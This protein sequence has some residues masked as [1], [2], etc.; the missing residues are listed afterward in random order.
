MSPVAPPLAIDDRVALEQL[1]CLHENA[2]FGQILT[3]VVACLCVYV[4]RDVTTAAL[5]LGWLATVCAAAI[6]R[7]LLSRHFTKSYSRFGAADLRRWEHLSRFA[8]LFSGSVW[9][10]GG[11]L[12]Y[13]ETSLLNEIFLCLALLALASA[14][15]PLLSYVRGTYMMYAC[16]IELP[17][18]ATF[19]IK[20]GQIYY[21]LAFATCTHLIAQ[22]I[23]SWRF[24]RNLQESLRLRFQNE[25]LVQELS[26]SQKN[27]EAAR[28]VA[29]HASKAKS[30]FLANMSHEIRTP[31]NAISG[32]AFLALD[33]NPSPK[34]RDYLTKIHSAS[35]SLLGIVNDILDFSKIEAGKLALERVC[36]SIDDVITNTSAMIEPSATN[37]GLR[38]FVQVD[39]AVPKSLLGDPLRL[40]QVILN[41]CSNAVKFTHSGGVTLSISVA[42]R[43]EDEVVL[44][45]AVI[46]TGIGL[47]EDQRVRLFE[48]F[49]QADSSTTRRYGG[50]GLGL[51]ISRRLVEMMEGE[52]SVESTPGSGSTFSFTVRF[53]LPSHIGEASPNGVQQSVSNRARTLIDMQVANDTV[54]QKLAGVRLLVAED[55]LI[56]QQVIREMLLRVGVGVRIAN[57][58]LE[59]IRAMEE[60]SFDGILMDIH[61]PE[62]D[63]LTA[64]RNL[65]QRERFSSVPIL[66]LTASALRTDVD[67]CLNAG[68]SDH[69]AKPVNAQELYSKLVHWFG[70][71]EQVSAPVF[72]SAF[73]QPDSRNKTRFST[74]DTEGAL[75]LIGG[76]TALYHTV[77]NAFLET[78][79]DSARRIQRA[80]AD[81]DLATAQR[82]VHSLKSVAATVGATA[83]SAAARAIEQAMREKTSLTSAQFDELNRLHEAA[84]IAIRAE[85]TATA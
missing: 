67:Q 17:V 25:T 10:V 63:G 60:T 27:A 11:V 15:L 6:A 53:A 81:R 41:L 48:A 69:I 42:A 5:M 55:N 35:G 43:S 58:G 57:N 70:R 65:R 39:T 49:T 12:L 7:V 33:E 76:D 23:G 68:M 52:V 75:R 77:L 26:I 80:Y 66:A 9:G 64:T 1:R 8:T 45:F 73:E 85:V 30:E 37:K 2:F 72:R 32:L 18:A 21:L 28:I 51:A 13:P 62:M 59:A 19:L 14:A 20:D 54:K 79:A 31:M 44:K 74:L 82:Y 38:F 83:L 47:T 3:V 29:D 34:L 61:M 16:A 56:N 78:E 4:L 50:T 24:F 71:Q 40:S 46:D 84:L 36:F 22:L